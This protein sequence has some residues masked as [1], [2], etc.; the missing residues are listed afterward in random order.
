MTTD[1]LLAVRGLVAGYG[2]APVLHAVDLTVAPGTIAAVVGA[3]GAG[4]TTLLRTLSGM[5]RP[6]QGR[7]TLAGEDLRGVPVEQLVRR[8]M[9]HVPEGRGVVGELTVDEN[10]RLGGLWRRDRAD[11]ARALDEVYQLFPPLADR[12][13]HLGHQLSGGERQMLALGRA[14]VGRPRLLLLDEPSLGLAPRVVA[15][16]MALLRRLRDDTGLT[17]LLVEQNVRSALS[18]ADQGVVMAL[19]RVVTTAPAARLR[20]DADLRHAYLGF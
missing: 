7:V 10:L 14:L 4:K 13:R 8:G 3:N 17:V 1:G 15:Q 16:I 12:R 2:A 20:D 11:A 5:L 19:G 18:V 6:T 9:A